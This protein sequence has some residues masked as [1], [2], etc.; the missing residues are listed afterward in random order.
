MPENE[1]KISLKVSPGSSKNEVVG[2]ANGVWRVKIAAPPDKGKA[3]K[4][5]VDF[6]SKRLGLR[7][8]CLVIL[9]GQTSHNKL[10]S[11]EGLTSEEVTRRLSPG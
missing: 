2:L 4:E 8:D 5:L 1:V 10:I 3:N 6:L 11:I 7:K 9:K